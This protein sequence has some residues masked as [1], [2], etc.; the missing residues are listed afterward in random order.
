MP[1]LSLDIP[2]AAR[3]L[4]F[5]GLIPFVAT[6]MA[7]VIADG[8]LRDLAA[9]ALPAY[10]AVI[11]SFLGGVRWGLAM[12]RSDRLFAALAASVL[13]ALLGWVSLLLPASTGLVLLAVGFAA[14]LAADLRLSSAPS[15]YRRL[16]LPLSLGAMSALLLGLLG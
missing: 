8:P 10:G 16:R 4:G 3:W 11:L 14:M 1:S 2:V 5:G 15:W 9:R 6:A 7:A 13:P 12:P